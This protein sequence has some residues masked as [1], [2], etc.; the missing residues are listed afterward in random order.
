[1]PQFEYTDPEPRTYPH[2][3]TV[4]D[5]AGEPAE[6]AAHELEQGDVIDAAVNPDPARF[7]EVQEKTETDAARKKR[8]KA[9]LEALAALAPEELAALQSLSPDDVEALTALAG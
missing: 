2:V 4:L 6:Y 3:V 5:D 8:E 9:E 7:V 1:M